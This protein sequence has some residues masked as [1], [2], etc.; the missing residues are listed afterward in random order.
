MTQGNLRPAGGTDGG[1]FSQRPRILCDDF[2]G[3]RSFRRGRRLGWFRPLP[4]LRNPPR[5]PDLMKP[6]HSI[7]R[8]AFLL[9][10]IVISGGMAIHAQTPR[11]W[12]GGD[13][14]FDDAAN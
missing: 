1:R 6:H 5:P 2:F 4:H 3:I 13:A 7:F 10:T 11:T 9:S 12:T 14:A 8:S